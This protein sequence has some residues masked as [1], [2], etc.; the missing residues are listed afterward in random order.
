MRAS[1]AGPAKHGDALHAG[2]L[3]TG[4]IGARE[5]NGSSGSG[6]TGFQSQPS[7]WASRTTVHPRGDSRYRVQEADPPR[8]GYLTGAGGGTS[9]VAV[10][11]QLWG[12]AVRGLL[13]RRGMASALALTSIALIMSQHPLGHGRTGADSDS[14]MVSMVSSVDACR[15]N[16]NL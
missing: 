1:D 4:H 14:S 9:I 5:S 8:P 6:S 16:L 15:L 2:S 7:A 13:S 11:C 10:A 12:R 3:G